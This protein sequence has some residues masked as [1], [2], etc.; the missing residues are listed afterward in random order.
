[1]ESTTRTAIV[2]SWTQLV[3][4]SGIAI[5]IAA[6]LAVAVAAA[7]YA[8]AEPISDERED[9]GTK[10]RTRL[11]SAVVIGIGFCVVLGFGSLLVY[12]SN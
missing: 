10:E 11:V 5:M 8:N 4:V 2:S 9:D 12:L 7:Y 3:K 1:M 6:A